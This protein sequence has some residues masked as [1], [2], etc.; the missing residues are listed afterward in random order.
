MINEVRCKKC[1]KLLFKGNFN[2]V[3]EIK[4][5]KCKNILKVEK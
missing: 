2:G 1:N 4:C 5:S 3:V